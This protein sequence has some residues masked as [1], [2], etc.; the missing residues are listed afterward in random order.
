MV[1]TS[2]A[3]NSLPISVIRNSLTELKLEKQSPEPNK[4][5]H[6]SRSTDWRQFSIDTQEIG[7]Y[8][9]YRNHQLKVEQES[10]LGLLYRSAGSI[11]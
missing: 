6:A 1:S 3:V 2:S 11:R 4:M 5:F 9:R 7:I 10:S 8:E